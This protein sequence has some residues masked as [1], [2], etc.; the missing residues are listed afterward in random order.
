MGVKYG[1]KKIITNGLQC[2]FDAANPRCYSG[3]GSTV[4]DLTGNEHTGTMNSATYDAPS[5]SFHINGSGTISFSNPLN[6]AATEQV[7]SIFGFV[8]IDTNDEQFLISS[9]NKGIK[10]VHGSTSKALLY[11]NDGDNDYYSYA[12]TIDLIEDAGW[13]S[14][15]FA[16][17]NNDTLRRI[18]VNGVAYNYD[19]P[20]YTST[21]SGQGST[22]YWGDSSLGYFAN[23]LIYNRVLTQWEFQKNHA[24]LKE[25][26]NI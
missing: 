13:V 12:N 3:T 15:G 16:F 17:N 18:Y 4:Y 14:V 8:N 21:P 6:Q 5:K 20:N 22:F 1:S 25:R 19:G 7:W 11:L 24:A 9:L 10:L 23:L 2:H 26:F